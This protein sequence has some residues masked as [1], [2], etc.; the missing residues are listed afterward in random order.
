MLWRIYSSGR[1]QG[2]ELRCCSTDVQ[3]S[4]DAAPL[5]R[6]GSSHV[7]THDLRCITAYQTAPIV[8]LWRFCP[9]KPAAGPVFPLSSV[10]SESASSCSASLHLQI[11]RYTQPVTFSSPWTTLV[12]LQTQR[13][14]LLMLWYIMCTLRRRK[15]ALLVIQTYKPDKS[16]TTLSNSITN[17]STF[18]K[19][20]HLP[21]TLKVLQS[22][23]AWPATRL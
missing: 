19:L 17:I 11:R 16:E 3:P 6:C 10:H 22:T 13:H 21:W 15:P 18:R 8:T 1:R 23:I 12:P 2:T 4:V 14:L 9:F 5:T 20:L 7:G